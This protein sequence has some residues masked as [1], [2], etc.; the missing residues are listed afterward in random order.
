M[1]NEPDFS[2]G[3]KPEHSKALSTQLTETSK[4]AAEGKID[5]AGMSA[6]QQITA[7]RSL[8]KALETGF[9]IVRSTHYGNPPQREPFP[10]ACYGVIE[11]CLAGIE[12]SRKAGLIP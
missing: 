3:Y 2:D 11:Q 10:G 12:L 1:S 7:L 6:A 9:S 5:V 8:V 4:A